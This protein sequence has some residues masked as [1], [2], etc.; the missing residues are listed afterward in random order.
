MLDVFLSHYTCATKGGLC[1]FFSPKVRFKV[2]SRLV[3]HDNMMTG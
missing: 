3:A 1:I 2:I